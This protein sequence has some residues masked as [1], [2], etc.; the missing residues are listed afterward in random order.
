MTVLITVPDDQR[1]GDEAHGHDAGFHRGIGQ[2]GHGDEHQK[3]AR[4]HAA[5]G[6]HEWIA[7][8]Q[9]YHEQGRDDGKGELR[10]DVIHYKAYCNPNQSG[11]G[12]SDR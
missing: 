3:T 9:L 2:A 7:I 4:Y 12:C 10:P 6:A 8:I 1:E 11:K 5:I